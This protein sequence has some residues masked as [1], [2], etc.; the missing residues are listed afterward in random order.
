MRIALGQAFG[1]ALDDIDSAMVVK[2]SLEDCAVRGGKCSRI[3][4]IHG[5]SFVEHG[6]L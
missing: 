4:R 2:D 6:G 1:Q 3:V 5:R